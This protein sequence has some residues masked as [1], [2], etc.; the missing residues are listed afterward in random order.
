MAQHDHG[1]L[2]SPCSVGY[3][4]LRLSLGD[5]TPLL[6]I[7]DLA[8]LCFILDGLERKASE[9]RNATSSLTLS[10]ADPSGIS[11]GN[12]CTVCVCVFASVRI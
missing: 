4:L 1:P 5:M 6:L 8:A 12:T 2:P 11:L 9:G 3:L 7:G 10:Q